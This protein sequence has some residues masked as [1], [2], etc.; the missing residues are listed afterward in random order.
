[1]S[2]DFVLKSGKCE[3]KKKKPEQLSRDVSYKHILAMISGYNDF[4]ERLSLGVD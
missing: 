1:V 4:D 3:Q 2:L